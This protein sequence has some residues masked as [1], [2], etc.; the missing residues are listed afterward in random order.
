MTELNDPIAL[1]TLGAENYQRGDFDKAFRFLTSSSSSLDNT[2]AMYRLAVMYRKG[3]GVEEDSDKE[4]ALPEKA[5][6][7]GHPAARHNLGRLED[8]NGRK[9]RAVLHWII[10]SNLGQRL[11]LWSPYPRCL[12]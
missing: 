3:V 11:S 5:A 4:R 10:A 12:F 7:A 8:E 1:Q 9:D 6:I 2:D